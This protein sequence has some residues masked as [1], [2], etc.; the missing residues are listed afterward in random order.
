MPKLRTLVVAGEYTEFDG[1]PHVSERHWRMV[2][3][4]SDCLA[5]PSY[6]RRRVQSDDHA[7]F[8]T[9][10]P[11]P[12]RLVTV[13]P[14]ARRP[15]EIALPDF[16]WN[17]AHYARLL[18]DVDAVYCRFPSCQWDGVHLYDLAV[19]RGKLVFASLHGDWAE[20]YRHSASVSG[21]PRSWIDA[22]N[23]RVARRVYERVARSA[24][25]LFCVGR[26]L[27]RLYGGPARTCVVFANYLHRETDLHA[28]DDTCAAPPHRILYVGDLHPRKGVGILVDALARLR[29]SGVP[30][31][32]SIVGRGEMREPIREQ[33]K[34]LG[35]LDH[36]EFHG[37]V[38]FGEAL[39]EIYRGADV[40][41]LPSLAGEGA[42]KV[43]VEAMSQGLPVVASDVGS[44]AS[45]LAESGGGLPVPPGDAAALAQALR[46]VFD[47][48]ERRREM[49]RAGLDFARRM[50]NEHQR[51][52]VADGLARY[53][54]ELL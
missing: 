22:R 41:V 16:G 7:S 15:W 49:I 33:A 12:D 21:P 31:T 4:F 6:G 50:T 3:I 32:L 9:R 13:N 17:R 28:R 2:R 48:G 45:I 26:D 39:F 40:F 8:S 36:L 30:V 14:H 43:V 27:E 23:A 24:R 19:A 18:D 29:E 5:D 42:P 20:T 52:I 34:S 47:D 46:Q 35:V 11:H 38:P 37:Y 53:V 51:E 54:R 10:F 25:V 1:A 44:T